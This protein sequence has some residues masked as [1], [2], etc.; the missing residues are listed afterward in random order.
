MCLFGKLRSE[1]YCDRNAVRFNVHGIL[2]SRGDTL[3]VLCIYQ[4]ELLE[5]ETL[6]IMLARN[7][8]QKRTSKGEKKKTTK[9]LREQCVRC[10]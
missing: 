2:K 4:V 1:T 5:H 7:R 3:Y 9:N 6:K 8:G 10:F